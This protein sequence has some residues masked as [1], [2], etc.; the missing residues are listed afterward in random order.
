MV[1]F[2]PLKPPHSAELVVCFTHAVNETLHPTAP[3]CCVQIP[4][5]GNGG[6]LTGWI[7]VVA[8]QGGSCSSVAPCYDVSRQGRSNVRYR[9]QRTNTVVFWSFKGRS[10]KLPLCILHEIRGGGQRIDP[11]LDGQASSRDIT[12][13]HSESMYVC[14]SFFASLGVHGCD[15]ETKNQVLRIQQRDTTPEFRQMKFYATHLIILCTGAVH[16]KG[17]TLC[18]CCLFFWRATRDDTDQRL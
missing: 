1:W 10:P 18:I 7:Q 5:R 9:G 11:P 4:H 2:I 16:A 8:L 15:C 12:S 14:T 17:R 3:H 6:S 13:P